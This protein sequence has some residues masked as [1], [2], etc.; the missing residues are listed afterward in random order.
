MSCGFW[1]QSA[2]A[3]SVSAI[4]ALWRRNGRDSRDGGDRMLR[5][6]RVHGPDRSGLWCSGDVALGSLLFANLAEDAYDRQPVIAGDGRFRIVCD[7]R[8]DNRDDLVRLLSLPDHASLADAAIFARCWEKWGTGCLD[9]IVGDFAFVVW[10]RVDRRLIA[11]RD[12]TGQRPLVYFTSPDLVAI[13]SM[14]KGLLALPEIPKAVDAHRLASQLAREPGEDDGLFD[15][16]TFQKGIH[17]IPPGHMLVVEPAQ[18]AL[19]RYWTIE[20]R[21]QLSFAREQDYVERAKEIFELAVGARLRSDG[22]RIGSQLSGGL[23][24]GAVTATAARLLG[25]RSERL[26]AFTVVPRDAANAQAPRGRNPDEGGGAAA[27]AQRFANIEHVLV[28]APVRSP[29]VPLRQMAYA[30]DV[31]IGDPGNL[32][33]FDELHNEAAKRRIRIMLTGVLGNA[34]LGYDGRERLPILFWQGRW[35][36]WLSEIRAR[37]A[38]ERRSLPYVLAGETVAAMPLEPRLAFLRLGGRMHRTLAEFSPLAPRFASIFTDQRRSA[39]GSFAPADRFVPSALL[40]RRLTLFVDRM[41]IGLEIGGNVARYG[42]ESR[43]PMFD[44]RLFDYCLSLPL[45]QFYRDGQSRRLIARAMRD[46]LPPEVLA[47]RR[48]GYQGAGWL[49][50]LNLAKDDVVALIQAMQGSATARELL[51]LDRLE[52]LAHAM[53][54]TGEASP[55]VIS[56]YRAVLMRGLSAAQFIQYVEGGN[57]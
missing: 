45:D 36:T 5:A 55:E 39:L 47:P 40:A 52:Y 22:S 17:R 35:R 20:P 48:R 3:I 19:R 4:L 26:T 29:L 8:L 27:V 37:A 38:V 44:K 49:D 33:W 34:T 15:T 14:P 10:D 32:L 9:H 56:T 54:S 18:H 23:D 57:A 16:R 46:V 24:S 11:A 2:R 31:P 6:L 21:P 51:D 28:H 13:A 53:P 7:I 42:I 12:H 50:N 41:D 30:C 43:S 25:A 1:S